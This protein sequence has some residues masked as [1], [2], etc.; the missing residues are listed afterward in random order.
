MINKDYNFYSKLWLAVFFY[1]LIVGLLFQ[2]VVM[3]YLFPSIHA[4][5]GLMIGGDWVGFQQLALDLLD[6]LATNG[7]SAWQLRPGDQA[8]AG[9]AAALYK[10]TGISKPWVLLPLN[11]AVHAFSTIVLLLIVKKVTGRS[12]HSKQQLLPVLPFIFF[13]TA[14]LWNTQFH[15]DGLFIL[16]AF[17][18]L[19][20]LLQFT[21][22]NN[23]ESLSTAIKSFLLI[24]SGVFLVYIVRPYGVE[25]VIY[26]GLLLAIIVTI[27]LL[28]NLKREKGLI[29]KIVFIWLAFA[30]VFPFTATGSHHQFVVVEYEELAPQAETVTTDIAADQQSTVVDDS[31]QQNVTAPAA[32]LTFNN[33]GPEAWRKSTILPSTLDETLYRM[34]VLR[35][36]YLA[37]KPWA[38][39]NIDLEVRFSSASDALRYLPRALQVGLLAPF[40]QAWFADGSTPVTTMMRKVSAGEMIIIYISL[41]GLLAGL[42]FWRCRIKFYLAVIFAVCMVLTYSL[43]VSN[44]GT[45]HRM[46][47]GFMM[48]LVALGIAALQ[49]IWESRISVNKA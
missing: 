41:L 32:D 12:N 42:W 27:N 35:E 30:L 4:G 11:A 31:S 28:F 39:S 17:L 10:L 3:P 6:D 20:G 15:K 34:A 19:Y 7:W 44:V 46:R 40:P 24:L 37:H 2:L 8:P 23:C 13:P 38:S 49:Q 5:D 9:I 48:I 33:P 14:L 1:I 36:R 22:V 18:F 25:M 26:I 43:V 45:L 47:Y 29:Y 16:G 21:A